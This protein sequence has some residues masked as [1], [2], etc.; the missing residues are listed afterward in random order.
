MTK[1]AG[2][3]SSLH[4]SDTKYTGSIHMFIHHSA[5]RKT[6]ISKHKVINDG[7]RIMELQVTKILGN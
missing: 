5:S 6:K 3:K 7:K 1:Q 2:E 4:V